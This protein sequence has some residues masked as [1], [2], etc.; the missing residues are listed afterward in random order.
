MSGGPSD[1]KSISSRAPADTGYVVRRTTGVL[2]TTPSGGVS[3]SDVPITSSKSM[4]SLF[5][6]TLRVRT[7]GSVTV[8]GCCTGMLRSRDWYVVGGVEET[9]GDFDNFLVLWESFSPGGIEAEMERRRVAAAVTGGEL[10][11]LDKRVR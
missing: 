11:R 10:D 8:L 6:A 1:K 9:A 7:G 5:F 3:S 2:T 4:D